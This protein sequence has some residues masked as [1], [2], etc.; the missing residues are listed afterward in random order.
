[1]ASVVLDLG[2]LRYGAACEEEVLIV[3]QLHLFLLIVLLE[4]ES[5]DVERSDGVGSHHVC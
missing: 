4:R 1:M 2:C 5:S 3:C